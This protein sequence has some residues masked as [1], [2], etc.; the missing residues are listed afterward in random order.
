V[1]NRKAD[2]TLTLSWPGREVVRREASKITAAEMIARF[3]DL[4]KRHPMA[5]AV[6]IVV[7]NATYNRVAAVREWLAREGW[8][9][10]PVALS[11]ARRPQSEPDRA[12]VVVLQKNTLWNTHYPTF[13]VFRGAIHRFFDNIADR[14]AELVSLITDTVHLIG[15]PNTQI[16]TA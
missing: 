11:A 4:E 14:Q 10:H 5:T 3:E 6:N 8:L 16:S 2:Q 9:P 1:G 12:A 7:D 15:E 13:A